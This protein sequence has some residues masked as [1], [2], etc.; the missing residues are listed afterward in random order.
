MDT[1]HSVVGKLFQQ[2]FLLILMNQANINYSNLVITYLHACG[3]VCPHDY[4]LA[5]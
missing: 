5:T 2:S 4:R 1:V 3:Q